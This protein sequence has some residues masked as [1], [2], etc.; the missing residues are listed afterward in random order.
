MQF[1]VATG[2][3]THQ[4]HF[5]RHH[6]RF[7]MKSKGNTR[8][9]H[10]FGVQ[11]QPTIMAQVEVKFTRSRLSCARPMGVL[12]E[13]LHDSG[14]YWTLWLAGH[15]HRRPILT[16]ISRCLLQLHMLCSCCSFGI[17]AAAWRLLTSLQRLYFSYICFVDL[18]QV[19]CLIRLLSA[20]LTWYS[21]PICCYCIHCFALVGKLWLFTIFFS[22]MAKWH[23]NF[24]TAF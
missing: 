5:C 9:G 19:G 12:G 8:H 3:W 22:R 4:V 11:E 23:Q 15:G 16:G 20:G 18:H 17:E 10:M 24:S 7:R 6:W 1:F 13:R 2:T 14:T 21:I